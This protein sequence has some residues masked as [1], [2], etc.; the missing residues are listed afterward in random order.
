MHISRRQLLRSAALG[1]CVAWL[2]G[3]AGFGVVRGQEAQSGVLSILANPYFNAAAW[4]WDPIPANPALDPQSAAMVASLASTAGRAQRIA[5]MYDYGVVLLGPN[6]ITAA[7]PRYD[8]RLKMYPAWGNDPFS[9]TIPIPTGTP[10]APG[11]DGHM[12]I[13]D[14]TTNKV[15][16]L[17]QVTYSRGV[18]GAS[19]GAEVDLYGDGREAPPGSSTASGLSRYAGVI[20]G[21]EIA[22][23]RI[24]HALFFSTD[25]AHPTKFRYPAY[26]TDG[27]NSAGVRVPIPEGA[28]VQLDPRIDVE[29]IPGITV[30]E[31]IV[32][33]ALQEFGA[34]CGDKGGARMGF[35]FEFLNT[36]N[37]GTTYVNAGLAWDYFDM[38][39][40]PWS[41]MR[42]LKSWNGK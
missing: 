34:Y 18:W 2:P 29:A 37:P 30:G 35:I 25:M 12:A 7:T 11:S 14:S 4:L 5:A 39:H 15:Y 42:V 9:G 27:D 28:R 36:G 1:G 16:G 13:A 8:V 40:I 24:P 38:S 6:G 10:I 31:I 23:G 33:K 26:K 3:V 17:W 20:R 19:W 21:G 22:A 32:A 41:S